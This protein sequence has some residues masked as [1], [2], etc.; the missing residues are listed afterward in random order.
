MI[1]MGLVGCGFIAQNAHLPALMKAN[2][3]SLDSVC[4]R[5]PVVLQ[6]VADRFNISRRFSRLDDFLNQS[7][8]DAVIIATHDPTHL[9]IIKACA[10]AGKPVLVEKPLSMNVTESAEVVQIVRD[11]GI[12]LQIGFMKRYDPGV[13]FAARYIA[14]EMGERMS[15]NAWYCDSFLRPE[16]QKGY[17]QP[18]ITSKMA[19]PT[20]VDP[21]AD[22]KVYK[23]RTHGA[24]LV[25]LMR[26]LGGEITGLE[27]IFCE[28]H[29]NF[30]W[31]VLVRYLDGSSGTM[32]LTISAKMD[33][34]EG[35]QVFGTQGSV[36]AKMKFPF[37]LQPADIKISD[38]T[39]MEVRSPFFPDADA[40]KRQ[41]EAFAHNLETGN[42]VTPNEMDGL[43]CQQILDAIEHSAT[44][45][46]WIELALMQ[47][48]N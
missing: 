6:S 4:E 48:E 44:R 1:R 23:L 19:P 8:L 3:V 13:E 26:F 7:E 35:F 20:G 33:W 24:H 29:G 43:A 9:A 18:T 5:D 40:Y 37:F 47:K 34:F 2:G 11:F 16:I 30:N 21:K 15:V 12:P 41:I 14:E 38:S 22:L 25:D 42:P 28:K 32:N 31:Q 39:R 36:T 27:A 10:E 46:E 45:H 17:L